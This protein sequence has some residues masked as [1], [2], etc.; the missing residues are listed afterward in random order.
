M[1]APKGNGVHPPNGFHTCER[2]FWGAT[3]PRLSV[4]HSPGTGPT[5]DDNPAPMGVCACTLRHIF[6]VHASKR[7][8]VQ[9]PT[10]SPSSSSPRLDRRPSL[11]VCLIAFAQTPQ[12]VPKLILRHDLWKIKK[13]TSSSLQEPR[14]LGNL[15][16]TPMVFRFLVPG[17]WSFGW[18]CT[19]LI[20]EIALIKAAALEPSPDLPRKGGL[21]P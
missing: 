21:L 15:G 10:H 8:A 9:P 11:E 16:G 14:S 18:K 3:P 19:G 13:G 20:A 6:W 4:S 17:S 1:L 7:L 2:S 12:E 5:R